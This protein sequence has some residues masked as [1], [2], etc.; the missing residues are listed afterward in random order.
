MAYVTSKPW[1]VTPDGQPADG[2][3][4][5]TALGLLRTLDGAERSLDLAKKYRSGALVRQ[6][7]RSGEILL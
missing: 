4:E 6:W 5:S 1:F 2:E 7:P 3:P